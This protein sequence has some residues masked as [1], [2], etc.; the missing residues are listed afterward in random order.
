M[1]CTWLLGLTTDNAILAGVIGAVVGLVAEFW[2]GW[3]DLPF[4]TK[5]WVILGLCLVFPIG[6]LLMGAYIFFCEGIVV[7]AASLVQAIMVG[8]LAFAASQVMHLW[9]RN[10]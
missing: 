7:T 6:A 9:I 3:N 8:C 10:R 4:E 2:P 1:I 5:R